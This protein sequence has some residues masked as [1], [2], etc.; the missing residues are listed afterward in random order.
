MGL[1]FRKSKK[2]LPGVRLNLNKGSMSVT[3][4]PKGLK[5]TFSTN[6]KTTTTVGL[7]GTGIYYTDRGGSA[8]QT[9]A[10]LE[11]Q[12]LQTVRSPKSKVAALVLCIVFGVFGFH[13]FYVGKVGSGILYMFSGGAFLVGWIVDIV[14]LCN[15]TFTDSRG[16]VLTGKEPGEV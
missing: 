13:R 4:G 7:P 1:R 15:N 16:R 14:K 10:T 6:G 11:T 3:V 9:Q 12:E 2:I 8:S 5:K